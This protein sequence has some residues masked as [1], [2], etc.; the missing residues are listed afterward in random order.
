MSSETD[1]ETVILSASTE[2]G[3]LCQ[4]GSQF[5]SIV[6][7]AEQLS[8]ETDE[9]TVILSASTVV[10]PGVSWALSLSLLYFRRSSCLVRQMKRQ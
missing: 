4:L 9:E 3:P 10:G 6:F 2:D 8:S 7:Q 5:V 1:E